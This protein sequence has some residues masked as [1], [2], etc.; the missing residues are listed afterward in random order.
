MHT[1]LENS[2]LLKIVWLFAKRVKTFAV[3]FN[4]P[5]VVGS[6][7]SYVMRVLKRVTQ[8]SAISTIHI[9]IYKCINFPCYFSLQ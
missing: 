9:C 1:I 7:S 6:T 2:V 8:M 5:S 4:D 3:F